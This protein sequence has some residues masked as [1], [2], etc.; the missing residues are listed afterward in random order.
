MSIIRLSVV[1]GTASGPVIV[2]PLLEQG[3]HTLGVSLNGT[4]EADSDGV[5]VEATWEGSLVVNA[6]VADVTISDSVGTFDP[7]RP[8]GR[9]L[10]GHIVGFTR[11]F[12]KY[13]ETNARNSGNVDL[14]VR[15][16]PND[17]ISVE[18]EKLLVPGDT[19][20]VPSGAVGWIRMSRTEAVRDPVRLPLEPDGHSYYYLRN[21][22]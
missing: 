2:G 10:A 14:T 12:R 1:H 3:R 4:V 18:R 7:S 19:L 17:M 9:I 21:G 8:D 15:F 6:L 11:Y 22:E 20:T 5:P 16:I 13:G